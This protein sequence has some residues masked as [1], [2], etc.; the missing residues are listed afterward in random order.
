MLKREIEK[1]LR[2]RVKELGGEVRKVRWVGR[3]G[4][5][6]RLVML[7]ARP[8][9][10]EIEKIIC[11]LPTRWRRLT[12]GPTAVWVELKK[13]GEKINPHQAREHARMRKMGQ[14]VEVV[15]SLE[16]VDEVLE[17]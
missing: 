4:A 13:P 16:R 15:D 5:P 3:N 1:Y 8:A 14:R 17:V 7:P 10:M 6:D 12:D 11:G 2:D 9:G